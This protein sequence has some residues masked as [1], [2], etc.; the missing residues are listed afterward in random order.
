M[1][2]PFEDPDGTYLV[3]V[4]AENQHSLWPESAEVPAGW[5][6]AFGPSGRQECLDHVEANWTDMRPKSLAD[7]MDN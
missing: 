2:N 1:T 7:A 6:V 5:T 4:N 3:L